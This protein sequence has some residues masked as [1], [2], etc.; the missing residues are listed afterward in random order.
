[1]SHLWLIGIGGILGA[2]MRFQLGRVTL[3]QWS[4]V[5]PF[6]TFIIN[7]TGSLALGFLY[8][9]MVSHPEWVGLQ[10]FFGIGFL[11]AYTTF[12]TFGF[13]AVGLMENGFW[14]KAV[15]YVLLS[16]Y[17]GVFAAWL[18]IRLAAQIGFAL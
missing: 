6:P 13:E 14:G 18:G 4:A 17:L 9:V 15:I 12:S 16:A 8:A 3:L 7:M 10:Y 11:G 1:V 2:L 5:F